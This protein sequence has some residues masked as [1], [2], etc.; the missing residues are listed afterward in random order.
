MSSTGYPPGSIVAVKSWSAIRSRC[1]DYLEL[2]KPRIT[3][4]AL[5]AVTV[6]FALA[7]EGTWRSILWMQSIA[8]IGLVAIGC[9]ALNQWVERHTD[10]FM[11]RTR[12]RPLPS[13]RLT[14]AEVLAFG[15]CAAAGGIAELWLLVN[16][17]TAGLSLFTVLMYVLVYTPMKRKTAFCTVMGA[18][19]GA[20]PPVL[21]WTAGGG[22]LD[23]AAFSLF[24]FLFLWQFPH[25]LAIAWLHREDYRR[26]GLRMLPANSDRPAFIGAIATLYAVVLLPV[27]LLPAECA[28]AGR[29]YLLT[30]LVFG[31]GYVAFSF[32][33][34]WKESVSAA[35]GLLWYSLLYL[36]V[37]FLALLGDHVQ[38]LR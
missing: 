33:F 10:V 9:S 3:I 36:P 35:R 2:S 38:L 12:T 4:M 14:S 8:G 30:A 22:A 21:G 13:G 18:I 28:L 24:A 7:G 29:M 20:L 6:G 26:A 23:Q 37:M 17:L 15:L 19:P 16:P 31:I 27:S 32:R 5:V 34:A 11:H 25:F 1:A